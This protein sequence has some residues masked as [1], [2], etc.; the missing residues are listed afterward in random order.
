MTSVPSCGVLGLAVSEGPAFLPD[1]DQIHQHVLASDAGRGGEAVGDRPEKRL[2]LLERAPLV[3]GDLDHHEILAA[4]DPEI[5]GVEGEI[6]R[7]V[8]GDDLE[9]I[10]RW[11]TDTEERL[12]DGA[13][14]RLPVSDIFTLA[15]INAN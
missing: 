8:L 13:A 3:P 1:L 5:V 15:Q 2:L 6:L 9:S 14:D 12:M 11:H 10:V 4:A 7:G